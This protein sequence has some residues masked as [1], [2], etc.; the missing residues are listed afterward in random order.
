MTELQAKYLVE[1]VLCGNYSR[2]AENL[3]V[4]PSALSQ[5][6]IALETEFNTQIFVRTRGGLILT[7]FGQKIYELSCEV[8]EKFNALNALKQTSIKNIQQKELII[9]VCNSH[10]YTVIPE[11][12]DKEKNFI[13]SICSYTT[14][15]VI[16]ALKDHAIPYALVTIPSGAY[17]RDFREFHNRTL[18]NREIMLKVGLNNPLNQSLDINML[19]DYEPKIVLPNEN[20][21]HMLLEFV[22]AID[23]KRF[24]HVITDDLLYA[25]NLIYEKNYIGISFDE[26]VFQLDHKRIIY[27]PLQLDH[28]RLN[29]FGFVAISDA[30]KDKDDDVY[31]HIDLM[32]NYAKTLV[33]RDRHIS[34]RN[35]ETTEFP[36]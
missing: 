10:F 6:I 22:P 32:V 26:H 8:V 5:A 31:K 29:V 13:L 12:L 14:E 25:N 33:A 11:L 2:A 19:E 15:E 34:N 20:I 30:V 4:T 35:M 16:E 1:V 3:Y 18:Y 23:W 9:P 27:R 21:F 17:R 24:V 28:H 7:D 36:E